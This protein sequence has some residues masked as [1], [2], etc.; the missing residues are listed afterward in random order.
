MDVNLPLLALCDRLDMDIE[1]LPNRYVITSDKT[2]IDR[3]KID[4]NYDRVY[5]DF[6]DTIAFN[7]DKINTLAMMY[8]YQAKNNEKEIMLITKHE[9]DIYETL[10]K[11]KIDH[12]L[13]NKIIVLKPSEYKHVKNGQS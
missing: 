1:I 12:N 13:F 4:Y 3:Y 8:L 9:F 7:R 2:Y 10:S 6:D 5:I 11:L